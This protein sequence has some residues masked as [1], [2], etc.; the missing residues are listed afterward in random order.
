MGLPSC[1]L[2]YGDQ[3]N[4]LL[5]NKMTG[6]GIQHERDDGCDSIRSQKEIEVQTVP[7]GLHHGAA[8]TYLSV[9]QQLYAS[10][11]TGAGL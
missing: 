3:N 6:K 2:S 8:G 9:Y 1:I 11:G 5:Q 4:L 10:A 7:A